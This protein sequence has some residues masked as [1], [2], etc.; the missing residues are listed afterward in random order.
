[1]TDLSPWTGKESRHLFPQKEK[2]LFDQNETE[3]TERPKSCKNEKYKSNRKIFEKPVEEP[4]YE[5]QNFKNWESHA[6]S[7]KIKLTT[8]LAVDLCEDH[9]LKNRFCKKLN[10]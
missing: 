6:E 8:T 7:G 3:K 10:F 1:M 4:S 5:F 9:R 2:F